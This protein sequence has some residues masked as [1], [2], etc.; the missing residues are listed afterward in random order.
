M[1]TIFDLLERLNED[2]RLNL[3]NYLSRTHQTAC[4]EMLDPED[5]HIEL[6][7][8]LK[9]PVLQFITFAPAGQFEKVDTTNS[10]NNDNPSGSNKKKRKRNRDKKDAFVPAGVFVPAG[11]PIV[12]A[13]SP[14]ISAEI[15]A[16]KQGDDLVEVLCVNPLISFQVAEKLGLT[17][18]KYSVVKMDKSIVTLENLMKEIRCLH[19]EEG[20]VL[21]FIDDNNTVLGMLK[22]KSVWYVVLRA[23][24]EKMKY[25]F[26]TMS[27]LTKQF[28]TSGDEAKLKETVETI[29]QGFPKRMKDRLKDI[30]K[31]LKLDDSTVEQWS[32]LAIGFDD[33][34]YEKWKR[35]A[36]EVKQMQ[37]KF[38]V[39]WENYLKETSQTDDIK[40]KVLES[41][42][43]EGEAPDAPQ[44]DERE[45]D[46][47]EME[48]GV[49]EEQ[50]DEEY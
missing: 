24:R 26:F 44:F 28:T 7:D 50:D 17:P 16:H 21:Y 30:K 49:G 22:K 8:H 13:S 41:E 31:W 39:F 18:I 9:K 2:T 38:P 32:K 25:Y 6:L 48:E 40:V 27:K 42:K 23:V 37:S 45:D 46:G 5:Q 29:H 11:G 10:K 34:F 4:F 35:K 43:L 14:A 3:L 1:N 12:T 15:P 19:R 36:I 20:R 47:E 33:W